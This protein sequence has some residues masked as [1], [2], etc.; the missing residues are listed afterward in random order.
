MIYN[1]S[2]FAV[3]RSLYVFLNPRSLELKA[4]GTFGEADLQPP[5]SQISFENRRHK[6]WA[7][8]YPVSRLVFSSNNPQ[9]GK[10][11]EGLEVVG[12]IGS[13]GRDF[14]LD[15]RETRRVTAKGDGPC[16]DFSDCIQGPRGKLLSFSPPVT[17][18]YAADIR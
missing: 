13:G 18:D 15:G 9:V 1:K 2:T 5:L 3:N 8:F 11:W 14:N 12:G 17:E 16:V 4:L 6:R 7:P 10:W